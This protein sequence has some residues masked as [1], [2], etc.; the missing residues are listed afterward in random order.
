MYRTILTFLMFFS[1]VSNS[2]AQKKTLS[3]LGL[4]AETGLE[5]SAKKVT[6]ILRKLAASENSVSLQPPKELEEMKLLHCEEEKDKKCLEKI[7]GELK[8]KLIITGRI[9]RQKN[10][11]KITLFFLSNGNLKYF[12]ASVS[13]KASSSKLETEV[14]RMWTSFFGG[15]PAKVKIMSSEGG[16]KI[17]INGQF[18]FKTMPGENIIPQ[19]TP[20]THEI[21]AVSKSGKTLVKSVKVRA[22]SEITFTVEFKSKAIPVPVDVK[23]T[24]DTKTKTDDAAKTTDLVKKPDDEKPVDSPTNYWKYAFYGTAG[25]AVVLLAASA[26]TG[27]QVWSYEDDKDAEIK[28][29]PDLYYGQSDVCKVAQ[30]DM[31]DICDNGKN[32]ATMTN[33]L[34]F[35]GIAV[36]VA[37][38]YFLYK[39]FLSSS[40]EAKGTLGEGDSGKVTLIPYIAPG[41]GGI[42]L[43]TRF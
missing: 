8:V 40:S 29:N 16:I 31:V 30:G 11:A 35:S 32:M 10:K 4:E 7:Q 39:G 20:G 21:K 12:S 27:L 17:F 33:V 37:S 2:Y 1:L 22:G 14:K 43:G 41:G 38:T 19:L 26:Y 3:V 9:A 5:K 13:P 18:V 42:S 15:K 25:T 24:D 23:N 6:Q 28:K 34:M 36:G